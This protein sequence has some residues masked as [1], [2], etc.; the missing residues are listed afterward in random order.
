MCKRVLES[1]TMTEAVAEHLVALPSNSKVHKDLNP[2][3]HRLRSMEWRLL[4]LGIVAHFGEHLLHHAPAAMH[5][6]FT[7]CCT[8]GALT[9]EPD[10]RLARLQSA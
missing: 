8:P 7:L 1:T 2:G 9:W 5:A 3:N 10:V 6:Y 4:D